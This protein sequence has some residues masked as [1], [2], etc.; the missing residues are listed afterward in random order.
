[1][2]WD[3]YRAFKKKRSNVC[4]FNISGTNEQISKPC[5]H[6][7]ATQYEL[8]CICLSVCCSQFLIGNISL[9]EYLDYSRKLKERGISH[10]KVR[11][12]TQQTNL[13]M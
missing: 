12:D 8:L 13:Q 2:Q 3:R 5:F 11:T 4:L 1:M 6:C 7:A 10:Q 9:F